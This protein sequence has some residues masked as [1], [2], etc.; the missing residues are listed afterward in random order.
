[1]SLNPDEI[2][3]GWDHSLGVL[4]DEQKMAA[5]ARN[6]LHLLFCQLFPFLEKKD[7]TTVAHTP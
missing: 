3:V 4:L 2:G 5:L 6:T 1:M 7:T